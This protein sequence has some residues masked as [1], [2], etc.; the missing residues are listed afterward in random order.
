LAASLS[1]L[2]G[3]WCGLEPDVI[4]IRAL[5]MGGAIGLAVRAAATLFDPRIR[6]QRG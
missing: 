6:W 5:I 4:L 1:T 2:I 3:V